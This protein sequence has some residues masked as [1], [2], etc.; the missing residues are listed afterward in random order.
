MSLPRKSVHWATSGRHFQTSIL[1]GCIRSLSWWSLDCLTA[2]CFRWMNTLF[3]YV[4]YLKWY[5]HVWASIPRHSPIYTHTY[6]CIIFILYTS[7][8]D[9]TYKTIGLQKPRDIILGMCCRQPGE[10][11]LLHLLSRDWRMISLLVWGRL[12]NMKG[13]VVDPLFLRYPPARES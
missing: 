9:Q 12:P 10:E 8:G 13:I 5:V 1:P 7:S 4:V 11:E 2:V 3:R 6:I